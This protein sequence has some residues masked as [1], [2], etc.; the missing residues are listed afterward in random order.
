[1]SIILPKGVIWGASFNTPFLLVALKLPS[2]SS[3][4]QKMLI[5]V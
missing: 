1:L 4:L 5:R 3:N 2:R